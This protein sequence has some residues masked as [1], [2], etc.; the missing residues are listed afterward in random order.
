MPFLASTAPVNAPFEWPKS[1]DSARFSGIAA[2]LTATKG[3]LE[4]L[5]ILW[6]RRASTSL[7]EPVSPKMRTGSLDLANFSASDTSLSIFFD[8]K[9]IAGSSRRRSSF[10]LT[11][12]L[13]TM[14]IL[15]LSSGFS[16]KS[17]APC[18]TAST[19][20]G[21]LAWPEIMITAAFF[22]TAR[23]ISSLPSPSGRRRS[24]S[25]ASNWPPSSSLA[26]AAT[27]C[28]GTTSCPCLE[29]IVSRASLIPFSSS[30]TRIFAM[31]PF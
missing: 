5:L 20:S 30:T 25:A 28:A 19:A 6:M 27:L 3:P 22:F 8:L 4:R 14:R 12:F 15:S 13:R 7:P 10:S 16:R 1:S 17:N 21:T 23:G 18:F 11:A 26:P 2:Q 29:S 9:T 31:E 24:M